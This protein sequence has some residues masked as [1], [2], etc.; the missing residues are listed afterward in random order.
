MTRFP[1]LPQFPSF[2]PMAAAAALE[3]PTL[4]YRPTD[5]LFWQVIIIFLI[6]SEK[7]MDNIQY[8]QQPVL[9][10]SFAIDYSTII[11]W[12]EAK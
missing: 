1:F 4:R 10:T 9:S 8:R 11:L 12:L 5:W 2:S 7:Y 6:D 3:A